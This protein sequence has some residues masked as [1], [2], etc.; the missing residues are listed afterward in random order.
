MNDFRTAPRLVNVALKTSFSAISVVSSAALS[1][2][3]SGAAATVASVVEAVE[4][5]ACG[6][7]EGVFP[8][9]AAAGAGGVGAGGWGLGGLG[10]SHS[11]ARRIPRERAAA[12]RRRFSMVSRQGTG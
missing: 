7:G 4:A 3:A 10:G 2:L 9:G 11:Q 8:G 6:V 12:R 1:G 5:G